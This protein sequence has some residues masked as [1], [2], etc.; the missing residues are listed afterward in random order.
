MT[1]YKMKRFMRQKSS[2]FLTAFA[3]VGVVGSVIFAIRDTT[4]AIKCIE[5]EIE[6]REEE[7]TKGEVILTAAPAYVPTIIFTSSTLACI[8]AC[9]YLNKRAQASLSASYM[10]LRNYFES[11]KKEVINLYGEEADEKIEEILA[12]R[13]CNYHQLNL[14]APDQKLTFYEPISGRYFE[15]YEREVMDAEYHFNR[16]YVLRGYATIN[17]LYDFLGL[18]HTKDGDSI[19][20]SVSD[21][22]YWIDFEHVLSRNMRKGNI[23]ILSVIF[24]PT[25]ESLE[26]W[27]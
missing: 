6:E 5:R 21:D 17:E 27:L 13:Y 14:D 12:R 11:Y 2:V 22:Y 8:F 20:W 26:E 15:R 24:E 10:M 1:G 19:G 23:Y 16:N 25:K 9:H 18:P 3:A 4:K 7:L